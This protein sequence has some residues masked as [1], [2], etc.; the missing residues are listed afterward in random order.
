MQEGGRQAAEIMRDNG[1]EDP[2]NNQFFLAYSGTHV[3]DDEQQH[4]PGHQTTSSQFRTYNALLSDDENTFLHHAE[5]HFRDQHLY[6]LSSEIGNVL[7]LR[8]PH[9][10]GIRTLFRQGYLNAHGRRFY[11]LWDLDTV[12]TTTTQ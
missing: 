7:R 9:D 10:R 5:R 12:R 1:W 11:D 3:A 6:P 2:V 4:S 8:F